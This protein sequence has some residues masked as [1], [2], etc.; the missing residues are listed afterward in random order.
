MAGQTSYVAEIRRVRAEEWRELRELRL[1]ALRDSPDAFW[2]LYEEAV[3]RSDADW[4]EWTTF[5][6]HVAVEDGRIVGMVAGF[7]DDEDARTADLIA[8]FVTPTARG[9]GIGAALVDAQ[10]A[11]ARAEGFAR[12]R[13]MVNVEQG[14]AF[15]LYE[16]CGFRDTGER[17][18]LRDGP[19]VLATMILEL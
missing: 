5:A 7:P 19:C 13:L 14:S 17:S 10:L 8:M 15:R 6:C 11:W 4:R 2:T 16:R 9:R 18:A 3:E 12:V 1:E